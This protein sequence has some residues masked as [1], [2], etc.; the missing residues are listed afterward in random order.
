MSRYAEDADPVPQFAKQLTPYVKPRQEV[1]KI[2]RALTLYLRNQVVFSEANAASHLSLSTSYNVVGVKRIPKEITG[3]RKEY[4][5]AIQENAA[6]KK[7]YDDLVQEVEDRNKGAEPLTVQ[8][9]GTGQELQ[10]YRALLHDRRRREKLQIFHH[11]LE[12]LDRKQAARPN[13][14]NIQGDQKLSSNPPNFDGHISQ[15]N[16]GQG[17]NGEDLETI[18]HNLEKAVVRAKQQLDSEKG[19]LE[20]LKRSPEGKNSGRGAADPRMKIEALQRTQHELVNWVEER[21]SSSTSEDL[22]QIEDDDIPNPAVSFEDRKIEIKEQYDAY[23]EARKRLLASA[24]MAPPQPPADEKTEIKNLDGPAAQSTPFQGSLGLLPYA[25]DVL[26]PLYKAQKALGLQKSHISAVMAR[27]KSSTCRTLDRLH[28]E[29]H[30]IPSYPILSKQPR[31]QHVVTAIKSRSLGSIS[32]EQSTFAEDEVVSH[33]Q[34]WAFASEAARGNTRDYIEERIAIGTEAAENAE[35]ILKEVY[36][37]MNQDHSETIYGDNDKQEES[38]IW[39][40]DIKPGKGRGRA[41][42]PEKPKGPFSGLNGKIGL[43]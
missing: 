36:D 30:L 43:G 40:T 5:R 29:S 28:D 1:L 39:T 33:A 8:R 25:N 31:F 37:I 11:Y 20:G 13:Y 42:R 6:A 41:A 34:A 26:L 18:I 16:G 4:L 14:L 2:R 35:E 7:A 12:E 10:T 38:D 21:L 27:E 32:P 17:E 24:S 23:I 3:L 9:L 22:D 15:G 19:L